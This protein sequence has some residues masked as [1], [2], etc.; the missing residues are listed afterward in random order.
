[1][2]VFVT[3]IC[4]S[5]HL[6]I[7][8]LG[9]WQTFPSDGNSA[10]AH[11]I[12]KKKT[13]HIVKVFGGEGV[14]KASCFNTVAS[15]RCFQT[16]S[17][18]HYRKVLHSKGNHE[19]ILSWPCTQWAPSSSPTLKWVIHSNLDNANDM[20]L[21]PHNNYPGSSLRILSQGVYTVFQA[22]S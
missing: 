22:I 12:L 20:I 16:R 4:I 6:K 2:K 18:L 15:C 19:A 11:E 7:R 10:T 21:D 1:M 9:L 17:L 3:L 14:G 5:T 8:Q 13:E